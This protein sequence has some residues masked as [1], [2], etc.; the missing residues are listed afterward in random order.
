MDELRVLGD[1]VAVLLVRSRL[2]YLESGGARNFPG[3]HH[4]LVTKA[5]QFGGEPFHLPLAPTIAF[6]GDGTGYCQRN[7]HDAALTIFC[8]LPASRRECKSIANFPVVTQRPLRLA[9]YLGARPRE[10]P[11]CIFSE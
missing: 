6:A 5:G 7:S 2:A 9:A 1:G 11:Q 10:G 8:L 4:D 3:D